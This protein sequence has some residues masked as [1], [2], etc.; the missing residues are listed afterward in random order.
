MSETPTDF[1]QEIRD[2]LADLPEKLSSALGGILPVATTTAPASDPQSRAKSAG[3]TEGRQAGR[4]PQTRKLD[5]V[6]RLSLA[7]GRFFGP[8]ADFGQGIRD[9][10]R[11]MDSW[12]E[13]Q[14]AFGPERPKPE[15]KSGAPGPDKPPA[16]PRAPEAG[17][18][19]RFGNAVTIA[20]PL[21]LP[22]VISGQGPGSPGRPAG[23]PSGQP[24]PGGP[25]AP[26]RG[27]MPTLEDVIAS[28]KGDTPGGRDMKA[29]LER[30]LAEQ[31]PKGPAPKVPEP[32]QVTPQRPAPR[33]TATEETVRLYHGGAAPS[34]KGPL[35]FSPDPEYAKGYAAKGGR[36]A[37]VSYV[38]LPVSS[39]FLKKAF[40]DSGTNMKAPYMNV[41]LPESVAASR[42][43]LSMAGGPPKGG[44]LDLQGIGPSLGGGSLAPVVSMLGRLVDTMTGRQQAPPGSAAA[45]AAAGR[46]LVAREE[47]EP[48]SGF[49]QDFDAIEG[50]AAASPSVLASNLGGAR[51][52]GGSALGSS[53]GAGR[54]VG[55]LAKIGRS[56]LP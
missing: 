15:S 47:I 10:R 25:K 13:F 34:E 40:D 23:G 53:H 30:M 2:L 5:A 56:L 4:D 26:S 14:E 35:W 44:G 37:P 49:T 7:G 50:F 36:D 17:R 20:G 41:E 29:S 22:V 39:P 18:F 12:K 48:L 55:F 33:A 24:P 16:P 43:Y 32:P 28:I 8:L 27:G 51:G 45:T 52:A 31:L 3:K 19:S 42:K 54:K 9:V 38:D 1:L 6:E 46:D 11:L 21:P